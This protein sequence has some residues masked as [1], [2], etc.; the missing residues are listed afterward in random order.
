MWKKRDRSMKGSLANCCTFRQVVAILAR[1]PD[2]NWT[3]VV[4]G[5]NVGGEERREANEGGEKGSSSA[6]MGFSSSPPL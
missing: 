6:S 1:R 2:L 4:I 3:S 5:L